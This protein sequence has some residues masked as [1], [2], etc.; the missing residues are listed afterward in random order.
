MAEPAH[1]RLSQPAELLQIPLRQSETAVVELF[2]EVGQLTIAKSRPSGAELG[3]DR[4]DTAH[5]E[6]VQGGD[7]VVE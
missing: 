7:H 4:V 3:I 2:D 5:L 6:V 1:D